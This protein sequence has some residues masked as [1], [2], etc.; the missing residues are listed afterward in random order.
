MLKIA[1]MNGTYRTYRTM[2]L[3]PINPIHDDPE[4]DPGDDPGVIFIDHSFSI[5]V[6]T[7]SFCK[8]LWRHCV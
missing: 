4:D 7:A 3:I 1:V 2:E 5:G 6:P 8:K